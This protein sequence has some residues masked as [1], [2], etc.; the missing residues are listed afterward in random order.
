MKYIKR[1]ETNYFSPKFKIGDEVIVITDL[2][3]YGSP[4]G[5]IK[6]EL[7][8]IID[9]WIYV[10]GAISY[11]IDSPKISK[12]MK[13]SNNSRFYYFGEFNFEYEWEVDSKKYNL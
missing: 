7:V 9:C 4:Y 5:I 11:K 12:I 8:K 2:E 6:G 13:G 3:K 1:Y 10:N